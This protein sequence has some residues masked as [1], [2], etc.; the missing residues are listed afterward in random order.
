[1]AVEFVYNGKWPRSRISGTGK[2]KIQ[3]V[4]LLWVPT[5]EAVRENR[6]GADPL[7]ADPLF[8]GG[9]P[10]LERRV[11]M[12]NIYKTEAGRVVRQEELSPGCWIDVTAPTQEEIE[13]LTGELGLDKDF[14]R[15]SLDEEESSRIEAEDNNQVLVI[16]DLPVSMPQEDEMSIL[17]TTTPMG[18]ILTQEYVFTIS[19]QPQQVVSEMADGRVKNVTTHLRARFLL[20]LLFR[21]A[22]RYL[23]YLKQIDKISSYTEQQLHRSMR[24]KELIQLLGLEKSLV[25]FSTSLKGNEVTLEK[26]LRG[27]IIKLYEEDQDLLEDVLVEVKQAIEMCNIYTSILSGT[28]DAFASVISNNL[29]IV[30]KVLA[31]I[32][33]V[34]SIPTIVSSFY[35]MNIGGGMPLDQFWW[36]PVALSVAL[37]LGAAIILVKKDMF[38]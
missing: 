6:T 37:C 29:N 7:A 30:M 18:I 36:F 34:M 8:P 5:L 13:Y 38:H 10:F 33:I 3:E 24:N 35:G 15:S 22:T 4:S 21:I 20:S 23:T 1:M 27:R 32:T 25:Y 14:V 9:F 16:V 2:L 28:M 11:I 17:Y 12:L 19:T 26:I 31:S